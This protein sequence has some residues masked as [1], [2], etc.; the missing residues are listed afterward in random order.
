VSCTDIFPAHSL[1][2]AVVRWEEHLPALTPWENRAGVWFKREDYFSP[3]GEHGPNGSKLRQLIWLMDRQRVGKTRVL[4]GSSIQS[5]QISM[6]A[7]V[8]AHFGLPSTQVVYSKPSTVL[9]HPNPRVAA[10]FG[11]EFVYAA[12]PYNPIIQ[13]RVAE[14]TQPTDLVVPYGISLPI[15]HHGPEEVLAFHSVGAHQVSNLPT[16]VRRLIIPAGSCNS[17]CS[18][19]V[20]LLRDR[21]DL[22]EI[23]TLGIGPD[24]RAWFTRRMEHM[25]LDLRRLGLRWTHFSLH[26]A[27]YGRYGDKYTGEGWDGIEFHPTYEG[28]M[29]RWLRTHNPIP[30]DDRTAFWIVGS[31]PRV[32]VVAPYFTHQVPA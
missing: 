22:E 27:G 1:D 11:A 21:G 8:G 24:K 14:L 15:E 6:S 17:L 32:E 20:G 30:Q 4:S 2:R 31:A 26:E 29:W 5:P 7:I 12:G 18:I 23:Y 16:G 9:A 28:R 10:G 13:R 3:L 25:G 19:V